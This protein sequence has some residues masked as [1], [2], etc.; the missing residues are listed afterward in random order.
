MLH[1]NY[2]KTGMAFSDF[3]VEQYVLDQYSVLETGIKSDIE[4]IHSTENLQYAT[5]ALIAKK[6]IPAN[7]VMFYHEGELIPY[8]CDRNEFK[9]WPDN[10]C[11]ASINWNNIIYATL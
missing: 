6:L 9:D 8:D 3:L 4:I 11:A 10:Y 5:R 7:K 2:S 1:I